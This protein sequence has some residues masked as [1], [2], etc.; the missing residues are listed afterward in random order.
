VSDRSLIEWTDASWNPS[1]VC[2]EG[3][4]GCAHCYAKTFAERFR[5]VA[6]HHFEQGFDVRLWPERLELPL[7]LY[8]QWLA[9]GILCASEDGS[10]GA[11]RD[12]GCVGDLAVGQSDPRGA[13]DLLL[14]L[15]V[16]FAPAPGGA[17]DPFERI[18]AKLAASARLAGAFGVGDRAERGPCTDRGAG[19]FGDPAL[20]LVVVVGVRIRLGA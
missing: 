18:R 1:T 2:V 13:E 10:Q 11:V 16:G 12:L 6:G 14:V 19:C 17:R 4:P 8:G 7:L 15:C 20:Q 9:C 3:S 5:G